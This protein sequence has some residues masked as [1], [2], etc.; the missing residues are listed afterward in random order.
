MNYIYK[1]YSLTCLPITFLLTYLQDYHRLTLYFKSNGMLAHF[2]PS[3]IL[4]CP[5]SYSFKR[6]LTVQLRGFFVR[7]KALRSIP[8][9]A[10]RF[11]KNVVYGKV[12]YWIFETY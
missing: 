1:A 9:S 3:S 7:N 8:V 5:M 4:L 11:F 6:L 2:H 10:T 12:Q